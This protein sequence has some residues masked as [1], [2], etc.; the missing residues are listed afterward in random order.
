M[1]L[2][3]ISNKFKEIFAYALSPE[4]TDGETTKEA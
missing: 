4:E 1:L 3:I 2:Q